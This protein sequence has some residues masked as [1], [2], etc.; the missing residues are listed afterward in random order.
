MAEILSKKIAKQ[1]STFKPLG[2]SDRSFIFRDLDKFRYVG[3]DW[4]EVIPKGR[5]R[6]EQG[7][8]YADAMTGLIDAQHALLVAMENEFGGHN[9]IEQIA[10]AYA[11]LCMGTNAVE[12]L[13]ELV[14]APKVLRGVVGGSIL[15][16]DIFS[17]DS[18]E[19]IKRYPDL[20]KV[21]Q[22]HFPNQQRL[23]SYPQSQPFQPFGIQQ[24]PNA[25][26]QFNYGRGAA[27]GRGFQPRGRGGRGRVAFGSNFIPLG[28][29]RVSV[30]MSIQ[31]RGSEEGN[32]S[33]VQRVAYEKIN[34][35]KTIKIVCYARWKNEESRAILVQQW[36]VINFDGNEEQAELQD[37]LIIEELNQGIIKVINQQQ[38][39][40][41]NRTFAIKKQGGGL[42][43]IMDCGPLNTHLKFQHFAMNDVNKVL[44]IW[45]KDDW[46]CLMDIKSAFNHVALTGEMEKHLAFTH[47]GVHYTQVG[48]SFGI[49]IAPMTF[50]KTKQI[51]IDR[52][53]S[54]S[55][56]RI[57]NFADYILFLMQ[58][59]KQL[60]KEIKWIVQKFRK[61][62]WIINE[63]MSI[64]KPDQQ[65]V[66]LWW[67]FNSITMKIQLA[68]EK[69]KE[70]KALVQ[71]QIK[72]IL[73]QRSQKIKSVASPVGKLRFS[74]PK[75]KRGG[76]HLQQLNNQMS[77]AARVMGQTNEMIVTKKCITELYWWMNQ[78][79][80]NKPKMLD[81]RQSQIVNQKDASI[82][83]QGS[84]AVKNNTRF[85]RIYGQWE[86]DKE[87]SNL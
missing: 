53:K 46:A 83:G 66:F 84:S 37:Q 61:Q 15:P 52:V 45:K 49:S 64:L 21:D 59:Q 47:R 27:A 51:V 3:S 33:E 72:L 65:F 48:M 18:F 31:S 85:R 60:E 63:N 87:N 55:P 2:Y 40:L 78:L 41:Q 12:Q 32:D 36:R 58:D 68:N 79:E 25:A 71:R 35:D 80:N 76:L 54:K 56:V 23:F 20:K 22:L 34:M 67:M 14:N 74:T 73:E 4:K 6:Q 75:F 69:R 7:D 43:R 81:K 13:R 57:V 62:G 39:L 1:A 24:T 82:A 50:A 28:G 70:L 5:T 17:D 16:A 10:H 26:S 77:K 11:M 42:R 86:L 44:E 19:C 30:E 38:V 8:Q 9:N 29:Q